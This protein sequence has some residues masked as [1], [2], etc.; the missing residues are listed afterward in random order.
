MLAAGA[1]PSTI[2]SGTGSTLTPL[3][4]SNFRDI[5][6]FLLSFINKAA[7]AESLTDKLVHRLESLCG[8]G[9]GDVQLKRDLAFCLSQLP[10]SDKVV[11]R[12]AYV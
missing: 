2:H 7:Q 5:I 9:T 12:L 8:C 6:R 1:S 3:D 10:A 4:P 11:K